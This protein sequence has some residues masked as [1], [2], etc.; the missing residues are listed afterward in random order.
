[1]MCLHS[2]LSRNVN[3]LHPRRTTPQQFPRLPR[4]QCLVEEAEPHHTVIAL[5]PSTDSWKQTGGYYNH[6]AAKAEEIAAL[7]VSAVWLPPFAESVSPQG[8]LPGDLYNLNSR[9]LYNLNGS[10]PARFRA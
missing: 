1:M 5:P 4:A 8:Y 9:C 2:W 3:T 7:G 6:M 10:C